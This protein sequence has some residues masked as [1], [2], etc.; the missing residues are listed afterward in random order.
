MERVFDFTTADLFTAANDLTI[1]GVFA[2]QR[3]PR[4]KIQFARADDSRSDRVKAFV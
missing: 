2:D 4:G 1:V 3:I